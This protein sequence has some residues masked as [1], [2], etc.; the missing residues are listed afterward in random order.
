MLNHLN[1]I[2]IKAW[3]R[4][5]H[6][7]VIETWEEWFLQFHQISTGFFF[8]NLKF[9]K[10]LIRIPIIHY[11][12]MQLSTSWLLAPDLPF[13][14]IDWHKSFIRQQE[15]CSKKM[16]S[17]ICPCQP[18]HIYNISSYILYSSPNSTTLLGKASLV[19]AQ[20]LCLSP[21]GI[22]WCHVEI[23]PSGS[24]WIELHALYTSS[25]HLLI[26]EW[27]SRSTKYGTITKSYICF[28]A[29]SSLICNQTTSRVLSLAKT[30][31]LSIHWR[32]VSS[33]FCTLCSRNGEK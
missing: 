20:S 5:F 18:P 2:H 9:E 1:V 10:M 31:L 23:Y 27:A 25:F 24:R 3:R 32:Y 33:M 29:I 15:C 4:S 26:S 14:I 12:L 30:P 28:S 17:Q 22:N 8:D 16:Y 7:T 11:I 21:D 19:T 6:S 13:D